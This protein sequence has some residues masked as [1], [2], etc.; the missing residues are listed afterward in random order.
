MAQLRMVYVPPDAHRNLKLLAAR[1]GRTMGEV[2]KE[3]VDAEVADFAN[4]WS[5]AGGLALQQESLAAAWDDPSLD[6]Y[7][8]A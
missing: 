7:N 3:L 5:G 4:P 6:V 1:K 2:V 8:D